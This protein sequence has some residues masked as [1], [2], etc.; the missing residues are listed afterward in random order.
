MEPSLLSPPPPVRGRKRLGYKVVNI[1]EMRMIQNTK[2]TLLHVPVIEAPLTTRGIVVVVVVVVSSIH[3]LAVTGGVNPHRAVEL[4]NKNNNKK[5]TNIC[6]I[7][8]KLN[9]KQ[10]MNL[11][12]SITYNIKIIKL[13]SSLSEFN[14]SWT[15]RQRT[16]SQSVTNVSACCLVC[17]LPSPK[18]HL[19][20]TKVWCG[21]FYVCGVFF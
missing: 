13:Y 2:K 11:G 7:K 4:N 12:S 6:F 5:H 9:Q 14:K 15:K 3:W 18:L 10:H 1:N 19:R 17:F 21:F 8:N 20:K 16:R